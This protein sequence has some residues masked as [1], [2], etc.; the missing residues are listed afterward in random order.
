M[1]ELRYDSLIKEDYPVSSFKI[2]EK[3]N[4]TYPVFIELG[5]EEADL[6][7]KYF[8][9][10]EGKITKE[11]FGKNYKQQFQ[12]RIIIIPS[13]LS[14]EPEFVN[15]HEENIR[16]VPQELVNQFYD[17]NTGFSRSQQSVTLML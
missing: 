17:I 15:Q 6:R 11:E 1:K 4:S 10:I 8:Q 14:Q 7:A 5:K 3:S 9:K 12:Q 16:L 13:Y 2:I